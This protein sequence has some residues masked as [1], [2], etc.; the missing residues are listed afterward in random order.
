LAKQPDSPRAILPAADL[1][2]RRVLIV[3]DNE[4]NRLILHA[5]VTGWGMADDRAEDA[6]SGLL[7]IEEAARRGQPYDVVILDVM[8]PAKDG[9]QF[10]RELQQHPAC[11]ALRIVVMTSL[12]QRGHAEQA[13]QAGAMAYLPKPVRH[14]EL[15]ACLRRVLGIERPAPIPGEAPPSVHRLVTRHTLAEDVQR[16]RVLIVEDNIVNQKL[17]VR[18]VEKLGFQ[19]HV[20][21]NGQ[22]ALKALETGTY[23][24]MLM[25]CQMPIMDGFEATKRIREEEHRDALQATSDEHDPSSPVSRHIPIIAVTANAMQGDRERCLAAGMDDYLAKPVKLDELRAVLQRWMIPQPEPRTIP[26]MTPEHA[27]PEGSRDRRVF[28]PEKMWHQ[29]GG[30]GQLFAQL[31][32][33]FLERYDMVLTEIKQALITHDASA[34]ERTAH[35]LKGTA[36]NLCASQVA[37]I[38]SRLEAVGHLGKLQD[39]PAIYAQLE[40]EI[41]RFIGVLERY[42]DGY[43]PMAETA[44]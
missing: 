42:R 35:T 11:G 5:L 8:M 25:D 28:D 39:A 43:E 16:A 31:V 18:M 30:D 21:E 27:A 14:D 36:G 19:P 41:T 9:L 4:S 32:V 38:A 7:L 37:L 26:A 17:A 13:R 15:R 1:R 10:A 3:D 34:L 6:A 12:L 2:G 22:E 33:L 44:A 29:I 24:A 40:L 20:V 23:A